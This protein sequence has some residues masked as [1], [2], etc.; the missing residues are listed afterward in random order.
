M[1]RPNF[2]KMLQSVERE[3]EHKRDMLADWYKREKEAIKLVKD[4]YNKIQGLKGKQ[5]KEEDD[6]MLPGRAS[7]I[8]RVEMAAYEMS[9][10]FTTRDLADKIKENNIVGVAT[11]LMR[12][13]QK[14]KLLLTHR[15]A[16][17]YNPHKFSAS[18]AKEKSA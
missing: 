14:N 7:L 11:A 6:T 5:P 12:L 13:H 10:E 15:G 2:D 3:Y 1:A 4:R 8:K 18:I 16:G 9:G 17:R